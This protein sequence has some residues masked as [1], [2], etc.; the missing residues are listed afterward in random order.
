MK[1]PAV[2][3]HSWLSTM[4]KISLLFSF[5]H[6]IFVH[7]NHWEEKFVSLGRYSI[8]AHHLCSADVVAV[9]LPPNRQEVKPIDVGV[10]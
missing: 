6:R 8:D 2:G 5:L 9:F 7:S 10:L 3:T 1:Q 4:S